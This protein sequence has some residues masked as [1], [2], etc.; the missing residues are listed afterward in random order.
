[1]AISTLCVI[2]LRKIRRSN[3]AVEAGKIRRPPIGR[4]AAAFVARKIAHRE[5]RSERLVKDRLEGAVI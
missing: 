5:W 1:M 2:A 3:H 4:I